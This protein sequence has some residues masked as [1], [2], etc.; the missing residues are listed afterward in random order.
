MTGV[1]LPNNLSKSHDDFRLETVGKCGRNRY[2]HQNLRSQRVSA[3]IADLNAEGIKVC[4][5]DIAMLDAYS[6][7]LV[8]GRDMLAHSLQFPTVEA[9]QAWLH[10]HRDSEVTSDV[11]VGLVFR[12]FRACLQ[13]RKAAA[14]AV[15]SGRSA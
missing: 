11:S 9:Y 3:M 4:P 12:E 13:R 2:M 1:L 14:E 7:G 8:T 10:H 6:N 5:A 15:G